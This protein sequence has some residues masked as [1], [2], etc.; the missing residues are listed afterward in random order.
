[1]VLLHL[2]LLSEGLMAVDVAAGYLPALIDGVTGRMA[3]PML[4]QNERM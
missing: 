2:F 3:D 4:Y 1:M